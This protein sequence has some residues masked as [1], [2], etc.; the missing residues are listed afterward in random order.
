MDSRKANLDGAPDRQM[1]IINTPNLREQSR[2]AD[3]QKQPKSD[4]TFLT[5]KKLT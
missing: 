5:A 4:V 1:D 2:Q 3:G